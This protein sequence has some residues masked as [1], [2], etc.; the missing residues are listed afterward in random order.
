MAREGYAEGNLRIKVE[1][2][3]KHA[4]LEEE[5][6]KSQKEAKEWSEEDVDI[7][8]EF[9]KENE[10]LWNHH[11]SEYKDSDKREVAMKKIQDQLPNRSAEEI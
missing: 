6:I 2:L 3:P 5:I 1:I 4:I 9:Y 10:F 11:L 7:L 8:V